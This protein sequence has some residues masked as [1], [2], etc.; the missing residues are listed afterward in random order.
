MKDYTEAERDSISRY[1]LGAASRY[2]KANG[3]TSH[4][5]V[6]TTE[7]LSAAGLT[8]A[9]WFAEDDFRPF[10]PSKKVSVHRWVAIVVIWSVRSWLRTTTGAS[11]VGTQPREIPV[12]VINPKAHPQATDVADEAELRDEIAKVERIA[13]TKQWAVIRHFLK[14]HS[15]RGASLAAG[16]SD[17]AYFDHLK[18]LKRRLGR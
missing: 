12:G 3:P 18:T 5:W 10:D 15:W 14:G 13:T 1:A 9:R 4:P 7:I 17:T 2:A 11:R 16:L 8:I 6:N